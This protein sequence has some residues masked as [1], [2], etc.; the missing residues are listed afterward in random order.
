MNDPK[1]AGKSGTAEKTAGGFNFA[2]MQLMSLPTKT[3]L[4]AAEYAGVE[5]SLGEFDKMVSMTIVQNLSEE[6]ANKLLPFT[7]MLGG[8]GGATD[9]AKNP[10]ML[11]AMMGGKGGDMS[12]MLPLLMSQG[13]DFAKNP[14]MLMA[15]M[16]KGGDMSSMLPLLMSGKGGDMSSMLPLL[17]MQGKGGDMSSMLPLLMSQGGD[18]AKNPMMLA[19]L[20][21]KGD[22]SSM[23]PMLMMQ[24]GAGG[25]G[26]IAKNP[27]ML[28]ALMGGKSGG[29]NPMVMMSLMGNKTAGAAAGNSR[30]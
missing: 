16:G 20:M 15:L 29:M 25:L 3:L 22:M 1:T 26:D 11:M 23:L 27:M 18:I 28:A 21:G 19:A 14:A 8:E 13:G 6:D 2:S 30:L 7:F 9:F 12:S 24:G 4:K 17:M 10:M 5:V